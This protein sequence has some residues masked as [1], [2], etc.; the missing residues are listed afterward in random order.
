MIINNYRISKY[1]PKYSYA[2]RYLKE[3][4]TDFSDIGK[5]FEGKLLT[6]NEYIIVEQNYISCLIG[7][8]KQSG[9]DFLSITE[10]ECYDTLVWKNKQKVSVEILPKLF[11]DCLRN[12]CW[13]KLET[14]MAFI[15]FGYDYYVYI[16]S[17]LPYNAVESIC[18]KHNLFC[19]KQNSPYS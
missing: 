7:I 6:E 2:G 1:N 15:H 9:V 19:N 13:C 10:L 14:Q 12:K 18:A 8:L 16:G 3:E 5:M 11:R 17:I 4:W